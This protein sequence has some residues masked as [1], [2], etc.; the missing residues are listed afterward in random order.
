MHVLSVLTILFFIQLM[1]MQREIIQR[2]L[3]KEIIQR[4]VDT[5]C[6]CLFGYCGYKQLIKKMYAVLFA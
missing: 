5:V 6:L 3:Y 1:V 2:K 4:V